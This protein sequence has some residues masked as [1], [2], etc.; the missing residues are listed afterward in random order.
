M[1][2]DFPLL[3]GAH[4]DALSNRYPKGGPATFQGMSVGDSMDLYLCEQGHRP[5]GPFG[6]RLLETLESCVSV[7]SNLGGLV[8]VGGICV[9]MCVY[10]YS[11]SV[12]S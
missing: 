10:M 1:Q 3:S 11:M 12:D 4:H 8:K 9:C 5:Q 2:P 7:E 6:D